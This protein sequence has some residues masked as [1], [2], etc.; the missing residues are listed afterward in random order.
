VTNYITVNDAATALA[1]ATHKVG[2]TLVPHVFC[3]VNLPN[4]DKVN[5]KLFFLGMYIVD[6][7]IKNAVD[8]S[9]KANREELAKQY[10]MKWSTT[11]GEGLT[12]FAARF[13]ERMTFYNAALS[14]HISIAS[15]PNRDDRLVTTAVLV[16]ALFAELCDHPE[17]TQYK[18]IGASAFNT[19]NL[20]TELLF[21]SML[22]AE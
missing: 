8:E 14:R 3:K 17:D 10:Y 2:S 9:W 5:G 7:L 16:G 19:F 18:L 11:L 22:I 1:A 15:L 20:T 12:S 13:L 4:A 6:G 21:Q